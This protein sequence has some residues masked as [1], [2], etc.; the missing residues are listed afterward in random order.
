MH[1]TYPTLSIYRL[2]LLALLV[3]DNVD[4]DITRRLP[5]LFVALSPS[6][7]DKSHGNDVKHSNAAASEK[8]SLPSARSFAENP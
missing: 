8:F 5:T 3:F 1:C 6:Q 2:N 7:S 4:L